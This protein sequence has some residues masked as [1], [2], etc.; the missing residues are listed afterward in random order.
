M[1]ISN[2]SACGD[3][4]YTEHEDGTWSFKLTLDDDPVPIGNMS[5]FSTKEHAPEQV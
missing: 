2:G 3:V 4:E 1:N 5:N